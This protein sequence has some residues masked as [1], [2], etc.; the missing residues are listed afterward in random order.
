M[1]SPNNP[2]QQTNLS[3]SLPN[4]MSSP[5][6]M[7]YPFQQQPNFIQEN[8]QAGVFNIQNEFTPSSTPNSS[9]LNEA[10]DEDMSMS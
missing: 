5:L 8:S 10:V 3:C 1:P 4:S 6:N 7:P 9:S 2:F